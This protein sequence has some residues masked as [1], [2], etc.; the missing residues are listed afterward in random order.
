MQRYL[1]SGVL[2]GASL[3]VGVPNPATPDPEPLTA[4]TGQSIVNEPVVVYSIN[5]GTLIG[6]VHRQLT[7]YNSGFATIAKMDS[8]VFPAPGELVDVQTANIGPDRASHLLFTLL[9]AGAAELP[10][11][12]LIVNDVPLKTLTVMRGRPTTIA[13]TFSYWLGFGAHA[14]VDKVITD[15]INET[16]PGL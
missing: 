5:G 13:N 14:S 16:F 10:D 2:L 6:T 3:L 12:K 1:L 4:T 15:F 8:S 11:Q 9:R 7:V